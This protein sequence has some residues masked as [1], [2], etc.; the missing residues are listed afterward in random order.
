MFFSRKIFPKGLPKILRRDD[1]KGIMRQIEDWKEDLKIPGYPER[2]V[3]SWQARFRKKKYVIF[4]IDQKPEDGRIA[5][6]QRNRI[7]RGQKKKIGVG[8]RVAIQ[9]AVKVILYT[10]TFVVCAG[11]IC[12]LY[13]ACGFLKKR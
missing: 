4:N 8:S 6:G 5:R 1:L 13:Y 3:E 7:A 9:V 2:S 11:I 12:A 10:R